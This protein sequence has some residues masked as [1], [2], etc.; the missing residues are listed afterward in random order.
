MNGVDLD[1]VLKVVTIRS[2][3]TSLLTYGV[4]FYREHQC[5]NMEYRGAG[6]VV[7]APPM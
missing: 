6:I 2:V 1:P 7:M 4:S 3:A 5:E